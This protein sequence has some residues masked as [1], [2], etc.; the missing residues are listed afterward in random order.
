VSTLFE[1]HAAKAAAL[2]GACTLTQQKPACG[3]SV[4]SDCKLHKELTVA[5]A[6]T[7]SI[8]LANA[9]LLGLAELHVPLVRQYLTIA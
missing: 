9:V 3:R 6:P 7:W 2:L 8:F 5:C 1:S 4:P